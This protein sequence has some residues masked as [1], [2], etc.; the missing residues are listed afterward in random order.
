[1]AGPNSKPKAPK[2]PLGQPGSPGTTFAP[3]SRKAPKATGMDPADPNYGT[4]TG[5]DQK[6][7]IGKGNSLFGSG[8]RNV[9]SGQGNLQSK[10]S[11]SF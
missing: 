4:M 8:N 6:D 11:R 10:A 9:P 5:G 2:Y 7:P 3:S 1:M